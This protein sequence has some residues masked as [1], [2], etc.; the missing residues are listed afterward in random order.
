MKQRSIP[1]LR[2]RRGAVEDEAGQERSLKKT[3]D[4]PVAAQE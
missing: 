3:K 1:S 4:P 2:E